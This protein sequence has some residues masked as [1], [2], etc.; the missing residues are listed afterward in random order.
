MSKTTEKLGK[1][2]YTLRSATEP[3][4]D[5][6]VRVILTSPYGKQNLGIHQRI[7]DSVAPKYRNSD[8]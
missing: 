2:I 4:G 5:S 8:K 3:V 1:P 7:V 6:P